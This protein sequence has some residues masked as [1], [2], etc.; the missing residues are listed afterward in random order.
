MNTSQKKSFLMAA[1]CLN[2]TMAAE[3][4]YISQPVLSRN[5]AALE[6]E[7]GTLLFVR[8]N[9]TLQLTPAGEIMYQWMK[10][11]QQS[12]ND[13]LLRARETVGA[14]LGALR[15][16]FVTSE[17]T[18]RRE[19]QAIL[20]FQQEYPNIEL[21]IVR[22][23]AQEL[24]KHLVDHSIDIAAMLDT[25]I[26]RD[27]R[28]SYYE[29][30]CC[31]S[32][33]AISRAHPLADYDPISLRAFSNE[34]FISVSPKYSPVMSNKINQICGIVG[35][36]PRIR[37]VSSTDEQLA[38]V[39]AQQGVALVAD[40]HISNHN[41]LVRQLQLKEELSLPFVCVWD[42]HNTNPSIEKYLDILK[43]VK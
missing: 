18:P 4:L 12:M 37:E 15:I 29:S 21:S 42:R 3:K 8:S 19:A 11:H 1:E 30:G 28:F 24:A 41:P 35:F 40:N 16:G 20:A 13:A 27:N 38:M 17:Q 36:V 39:E 9:N 26:T 22:K 34:L 10:E 31:R 33:V 5:I 32:V 6:E 14:T 23:P 7:F 2:F 25:E 43:N